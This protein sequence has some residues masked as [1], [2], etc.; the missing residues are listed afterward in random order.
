M[1]SMVLY[2]F[3]EHLTDLRPSTIYL[4][5]GFFEFVHWEKYRY[6]AYVVTNIV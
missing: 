1:Q 2:L 3:F 5:L 4:S 6:N